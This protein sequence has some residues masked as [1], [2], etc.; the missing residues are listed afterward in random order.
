MFLIPTIVNHVK[1]TDNKIIMNYGESSY[2]MKVEGNKTIIYADGKK[3]GTEKDTEVYNFV[4]KNFNKYSNKQLI[5]YSEAYIII[6]IA[7]MYLSSIVLKLAEKLFKNINKNKTPFTSNNVELLQNIIKFEIICAIV[8]FVG[9]LVFNMI[10]DAN[11]FNSFESF[12][13]VELL[14]TIV[15]YYLFK[16]ATSLQSNSKQNLFDE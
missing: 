7:Y 1:I 5:G 8:P 13:I 14:I 10:V 15:I 9:M 4:N 6:I 3:V 12:N 16:Y 2:E 11:A